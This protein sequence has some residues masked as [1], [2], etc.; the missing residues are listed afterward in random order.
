MGFDDDLRYAAQIDIFD[1]VPK[2]YDDRGVKVL[3]TR[4]PRSKQRAN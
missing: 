4:L 3:R 2:L 1:S